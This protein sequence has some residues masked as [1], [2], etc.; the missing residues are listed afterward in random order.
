MLFFQIATIEQYAI[1]AFADAL[2]FIPFALAE[3]SGFSPIKIVSDIKS[4]QIT[5]NNSRLGVDCLIK[6]T[7][8]N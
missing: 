6:G 4:R 7:N 8:G 5:E 3:N 2:E 1:R